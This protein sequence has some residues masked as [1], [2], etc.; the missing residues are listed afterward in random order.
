MGNPRKPTSEL[1]LHGAYRKDRHGD[2]VDQLLSPAVPARP[3]GLDSIAA[4][5]WDRIVQHIGRTGALTA[6]DSE[7]IELAARYWSL[8]KRAV[9]RCEKRPMDRDFRIQ[10]VAYGQEWGK[11]AS[12]LGLNPVDRARL[13]G[14]GETPSGDDREALFF[15]AVS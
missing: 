15:G 9:R 4:E 14:S 2:R 12:K 5:H 10:A 3:D 13:S 6:I 7:A 8:W 1:K 11:A